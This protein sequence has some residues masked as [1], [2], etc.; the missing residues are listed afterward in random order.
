MLSEPTAAWAGRRGWVHEA[1]IHDIADL[2]R[3]D[4]YA[5]GPPEMIAAVRR[6]LGSRG[7]PA[8]RMSTDS[9]DYAKE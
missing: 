9:F 7:V 8:D 5:S 4:V 6:E 1:V 2:S 3:Y